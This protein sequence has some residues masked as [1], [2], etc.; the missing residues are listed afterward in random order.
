MFDG[1][2]GQ[3]V[4]GLGP[5]A[6]AGLAVLLVLLGRLIPLR[7]HL[8]ELA[9]AN[10]RAAEWKAAWATERARADVLA[11]QLAHILGAVDTVSSREPT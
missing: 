7:S 1:L 5:T 11:G 9:A 10:T 4:G 8:R 3:L 6:L 2:T